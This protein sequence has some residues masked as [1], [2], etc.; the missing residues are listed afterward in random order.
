MLETSASETVDHFWG[1]VDV[2]DYGVSYHGYSV[3][4]LFYVD[5]RLLLCVGS[6]SG[7]LY[8]YENVVVDGLALFDEVTEQW[9]E[10]CPGMPASFGMRSAAAVAELDG[11]GLLEI[12][13]GQFGGGLQL[14]NAEISVQN[15]G[16]SEQTEGLEV[17]IFPNPVSSQLHIILNEDDRVSLKIMDL[18]GRMLME[19]PVCG[20]EALVEVGDWSPGV[21]L[22]RLVTERGAV[23]RIFLKR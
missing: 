7:K 8:L 11:D 20:K 16:V 2:R 12:L 17:M 22:L 3:P 4:S 15:L 13:V 9:Q 23:S 5:G 10:L 19:R 18:Y 1:G 14:F 21:Y 6:E